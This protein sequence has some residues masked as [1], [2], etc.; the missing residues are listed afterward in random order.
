MSSS[1]NNNTKSTPLM[2]NHELNVN[3]V[4]DILPQ[5]ETLTAKN[6]NR[7][8]S[9]YEKLPFEFSPTTVP[10]LERLALWLGL[11]EA[12]EAVKVLCA[13]AIM[14]SFEEHRAAPGQS[15]AEDPERLKLVLPLYNYPRDALMQQRESNIDVSAALFADEVARYLDKKGWIDG[16]D[17]RPICKNLDENF[18]H[19][20]YRWAVALQIYW[21]M[22]H[23]QARGGSGL[24]VPEW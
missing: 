14:K 4:N 23:S 18:N 3:S 11:N 13:P 1:S 8:K 17:L 15:V 6:S 21:F 12:F 20:K 24:K 2:S 7:D 10:G 16:V 22:E 19:T 5:I 9:F